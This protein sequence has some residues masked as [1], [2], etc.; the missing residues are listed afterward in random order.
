MK[1]HF[2]ILASAILLISFARPAAAKIDLVTLPKVDST[3][4]TIY[5]EADLTL[6]KD[7][8]TLTIA[9]GRNKLQFSWENTLID[10][11]SLEMRPES[12]SAKL[13]I[14]ELIFP[15]RVRNLGIWDMESRTAGEV[16]I[17]ISYMTSGLSWRA[18][19]I[20][21]LDDDK[22]SMGLLG[23]VRVTNNSG[24][25]YAGAQVRLLVGVVNLKD[26]IAS[27]AERKEPYGRPIPPPAPRAAL[28][29]FAAGAAP[30]PQL[31]TAEMAAPLYERPREIMK[32]ALSEYQLYTIEGKETIPNGWSKRMPSMTADGV[33]IT[34]LYKYD[35]ERYGSGVVHFISF[36]NDKEHGL[37]RNPLP[38]GRVKIYRRLKDGGLSY[39]GQSDMKYIPLKQKVEL[40]LG[41]A[42]GIMVEPKLMDYST[43]HF[44]YDK[45]GGIVGHDETDSYELTVRNTL[46]TPAKIEITREPKCSSWEIKNSGDYGHY[47]KLDMDHV[48]YTLSLGPGETRKFEYI[49]T[50][51]FG[52]R[53]VE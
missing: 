11:T 36:K 34:N 46:N 1:N 22:P 49:V 9:K 24:E 15:P 52:E 45:T 27:L 5:N 3:Q 14:D 39:V 10:P 6:V 12:D 18:F 30:R 38:E 43:S 2:I 51:H 25:D 16:P 4:L 28:K 42:Q 31:E 50:Q 8:R 33:G 21:I 48:K 44:M 17:E 47:E 35:L 13:N 26:N 23:Y 41:A 40:S 53:A 19:Y 7:L 29:K 20:G 37:G 32:Q